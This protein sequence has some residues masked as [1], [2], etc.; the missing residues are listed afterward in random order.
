MTS[1]ASF[2]AYLVTALA[3]IEHGT[4]QLISRNDLCAG[5]NL[6]TKLLSHLRFADEPQRG[7]MRWC[8]QQDALADRLAMSV[9]EG[10]TD[11]ATGQSDFQV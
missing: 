6:L 2:S 11:S 4:N 7:A 5:S 8:R 10:R 9:R 3:G 1:G